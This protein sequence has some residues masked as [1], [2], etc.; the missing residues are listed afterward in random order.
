MSYAINFNLDNS[1]TP[2]TNNLKVEARDPV[3]LV[4]ESSLPITAP[5]D[6]P[7]SVTIMVEEA[8][9]YLI[10][11]VEVTGGGDVVLNEYTEDSSQQIYSTEPDLVW[12]VDRSEDDPVSGETEFEVPALEGVEFRFVQRGVGAMQ[13]GVEFDYLPTGGVKWLGGRDFSSGDTFHVQKYPPSST[14][15]RDIFLVVG[16]GLPQDPITGTAQY[17][18]SPLAGKRYRIEKRGTGPKRND[19]V[20]IVPAGGFDLLGGDI[21]AGADTWVIHFYPTIVLQTSGSSG[22]GKGYDGIVELTAASTT[23]DQTYIGKLIRFKGTG[24]TCKAILPLIGSFPQT[25]MLCFEHAGG[26]SLFGTIETQSGQDIE[27]YWDDDVVHNDQAWIGKNEYMH[28]QHDGTRWI[29]V[30]SNWRINEVGSFVD[31][32]R[33]LPNTIVADRSEHVRVEQPRVWF[34]LNQF[35]STQLV[36]ESTYNPDTQRGFFTNGDGFATFRVPNWDGVHGF[37]GT[38][39]VYEA[40]QVGEFTGSP[41]PAKAGS[42]GGSSDAET[43]TVALLNNNG[44]AEVNFTIKASA[45][46]H[47]EGKVNRP[48]RIGIMKLIRT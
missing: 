39:A 19:E 28:I 13:P 14:V 24:T 40:D 17:R 45:V 1:G 36:S 23:L 5:H 9:V 6:F 16:R 25:K 29:I 27:F 15:P 30:S 26:N 42:H 32:Y 7:I 31:A 18:Y 46:V 41:I 20:T 37:A 21:F 48:K 22:S 2:I 12:V 3:S 4:L 35:Y 11:I 8:K 47:N 44:T 34:I 33:Q 43:G 38:P 10:R